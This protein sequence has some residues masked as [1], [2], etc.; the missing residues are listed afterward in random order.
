MWV[1]I[2]STH[3]ICLKITAVRVRKN[4]KRSFHFC[5]LYADKVLL[6]PCE[7]KGSLRRLKGRPLGR[8]L[9]STKK[10]REVRFQFP[11]SLS[12]LF[13]LHQA[14]SPLKSILFGALVDI[15]IFILHF[16]STLFAKQ[17]DSKNTK[18]KQYTVL[19]LAE[20]TIAKLKKLARK[21]SS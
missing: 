1:N 17:Y 9:I 19:T 6:Y 15:L 12:D 16:L 10:Q 5:W 14:A 20:L 18:R 7:C 13:P 3:Q 8:Q 4:L 21:N 2:K 11:V